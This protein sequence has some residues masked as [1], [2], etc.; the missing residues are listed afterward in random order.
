ML[1]CKFYFTCDRSYTSTSHRRGFTTLF[2]FR[3]IICTDG[4]TYTRRS[5]L[6]DRALPIAWNGFPSAIR[7]AATR[8]TFRQ[9]LKAHLF[10][11]GFDCQ[12]G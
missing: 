12:R 5:T 3:Q 1:Y 8:S 11:V 2:S 6:A 9:R 10:R 4:N 7:E